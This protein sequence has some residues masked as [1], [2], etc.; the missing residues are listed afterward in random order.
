MEKKM[1]SETTRYIT[2]GDTG[3]PI[4]T[5]PYLRKELK[6]G[7]EIGDLQ[8]GMMETSPVIGQRGQRDCL[9]N[10]ILEN[11]RLRKIARSVS[12]RLVAIAE[13]KGIGRYCTVVHG[14]LARGL[15]RHTESCDPS[16]IDID[17]VIGSKRDCQN[18]RSQV[19]EQMYDL[20]DHFGVRIDSYVWNI[21]EMRRNKGEY[22]RL[23]L[24]AG[25][26]SITCKGKIWEEIQEV[27]IESQKFINLDKNTKSQLFKRLNYILTNN[28]TEA[29]TGFKSGR[30]QSVVCSYFGETLEPWEIILKAQALKRLIMS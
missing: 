10:N 13:E 1:L 25:A 12:K 11:I 22:A 30:M 9:P 20:S 3:L 18:L 2:H 26:Y 16:D 24:G 19:R 8:R 6:R 7:S 28:I 23:Y 29:L 17:L 21:E 4:R 15:V 27:G 14:S 5:P